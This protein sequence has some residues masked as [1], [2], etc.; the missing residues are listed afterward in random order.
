MSI[1]VCFPYFYSKN[2][3]TFAALFVRVFFFYQFR[4]L[5]KICITGLHVECYDRISL[6]IVTSSIFDILL[7]KMFTRTTAG[8]S[9]MNRV[10]KKR[11]EEAKREKDSAVINAN[12]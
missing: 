1:A 2:K 9:M 11:V 10:Q 8:P 6:T 3:L 7:T 12:S 5:K 4:Q